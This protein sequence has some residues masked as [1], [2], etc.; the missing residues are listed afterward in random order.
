MPEE[1]NKQLVEDLRKGNDAAYQLLYKLHYKVLCAFA[2]GYVKDYFTAET[3]V[4]DVIFNVWENRVSLTIRQSLRAYLMQAV[5]NSCINYLEYSIRQENLKQSVSQQMRN[6]Q[7]S[8]HEQKD[9]PL[10]SL[11]EKELEKR[12][13]ESI[14][15]LPEPTR[16]I[17]L[18]SRYEGLKYEEIAKQKNITID[19]VKYHI[20]LSLNHLR[21]DLKEYLS[22]GL[23]LLLSF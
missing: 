20:R 10:C 19:I 2:Y 12:I 6:L 18:M 17:F 23:L 15:N 11:L 22:L 7:K 16:G 13:E 21:I 4:S 5:K 3:L 1:Q 8:F 9:Y 14:S